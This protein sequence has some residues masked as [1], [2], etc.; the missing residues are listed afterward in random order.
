MS[1]QL[2]K[3]TGVLLE[4]YFQRC[5]G[6]VPPQPTHPAAEALWRVAQEVQLGNSALFRSCEELD[7]EPCTIL[8]RVAPEVALDGG[9]NWGRVVVLI[10]F[11]GTLVQRHKRRKAGTPREL[12]GVLSRFLGREHGDWLQRSGGWEGFQNFSNK[13]NQ[14]GQENSHFSSALMAAAG[15]GLAGLVFLLAVR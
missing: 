4:D 3:E 10:A 11:A 1:E 2:E 5:L 12:A 13:G 14:R 15:V 7:V 8:E 6:Q 9:L